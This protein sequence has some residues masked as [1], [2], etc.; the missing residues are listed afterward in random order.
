MN[1]DS[2]KARLKQY[3]QQNG[4]T[5]QEMLV[6]YGL[7][8]T[9][10][11]LSVSEYA[12]HFVLKGGIFLY[13]VFT[14]KY[15]RATTDIDFLARSISNSKDKM[16]SVF[17]KILSSEYDDGL[18]YDTDSVTVEDITE[19]KE[20]H[21]LH[22]SVTAYLDRTKIP[23]GIDIGFGDVIFPDSV[24]MDF[25]VI[26]DMDAPKINAYSVESVVA[27]KLEAI[28]HNGFLNSRYKDFYDIYI[29]SEKYHFNYSDLLS[30]VQETFANRKTELTID[31]AAFSDDFI[32]DDIHT[33]RWNAFLKK[34]KA[35][36]SI[37]LEDTVRRIKSFVFPLTDNPDNSIS[38]W[39]PDIGSWE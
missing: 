28:I 14:G 36:K 13:A 2:V 25:P 23:I 5:F 6:Y 22:I 31:S 18:K 4:Y 11:R 30:A 34:K 35:I 32:N 39:N 24:K 27:E 38:C 12:E 7:E 3:A 1:A 8:R 37:S 17:Q 9:I 21:G 26:L 20:Y 16:K 19:F 10:Y 15:E 29:L 33:K